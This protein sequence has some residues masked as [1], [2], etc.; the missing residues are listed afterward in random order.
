[1]RDAD[2]HPTAAESQEKRVLEKAQPSG[3]SGPVERAD[4]K[5]TANQRLAYIRRYQNTWLQERRR[6]AIADLGGKCVRCGSTERLEVDHI[7]PAA[8]VSHR[9]WGWSAE[10][11][12]A[13][14]AKCQVLCRPCHHKKTG[15]EKRRPITHGT[16]SGYRR[17]CR[18]LPC[19]AANRRRS[20]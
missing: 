12:A 11:R 5:L 2:L 13:E 7:D 4:G 8:K 3:C 16:A 1:M 14:L 20:A 10:K 15:A 19:G 6:Q 18:C 17:G 9:I